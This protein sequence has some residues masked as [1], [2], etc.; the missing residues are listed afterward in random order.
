M[1][2]R[3]SPGA[4]D[5]RDGHRRVRL[6]PA[7]ADLAGTGA[8]GGG[9]VAYP[10]DDA[11]P[12]LLAGLE[13]LVRAI[14]A[15][16]EDAAVAAADRLVDAVRGA[17]DP[18]G[19]AVVLAGIMASEHEEALAAGVDAAL[20][21]DF[22]TLA[23]RIGRA[24]RAPSFAAFLA[25]RAGHPATAAQDRPADARA[26]LELADTGEPEVRLA[27]AVILAALVVADPDATDPELREVG[28]LLDGVDVADA[29]LDLDTAAAVAA[30]RSFAALRLR[31]VRG[32]L[33][34]AREGLDRVDAEGGALGPPL[35]PA[36]AA[37]FVAAVL[38]YP[39]RPPTD[40]EAARNAAVLRRVRTWVPPD[41]ALGFRMG[42]I[43]A[44]G[45]GSTP[46]DP[47]LGATLDELDAVEASL[48]GV[49]RAVVLLVKAQRAL[50]LGDPSEALAC[51]GRLRALVASLPPD[52]PVAAGYRMLVRSLDSVGLDAGA[53]ARSRPSAPTVATA[54]QGTWTRDAVMA[55]LADDRRRALSGVP[56]PHLADELLALASELDPVELADARLS[57]LQL[58]VLTV[59][60]AYGAQA[61]ADP[62]AAFRKALDILDRIDA[63]VA[64][65]RA[66]SPAVVPWL[67]VR[68][69][70]DVTRA[71]TLAAT[72]RSAEARATLEALRVVPE[73]A[74]SPF[75]TAVVA[76]ARLGIAD[77]E[78]NR[79]EVLVA[80]CEVL[81]SVRTVQAS[82]PSARD[83]LRF[84]AVLRQAAATAFDA[85]AHDAS[86]LAEV[87][88]VV[89]AQAMP[90]APA[91]PG[92][93]QTPLAVLM[94][95]LSGPDAFDAPV[96]LGTLGARP[97]P[98]GGDGWYVTQ[99]GPPPQVRMPGGRV[100]LGRYRTVPAD[101]SRTVRL[102]IPR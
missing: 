68:V 53:E 96:P 100:A 17:Q 22:L 43:W 75:F 73:V 92:P 62:A 94:D 5:G 67:T 28:V 59:P 33:G 86:T 8:D 18:A 69:F 83:R 55:R 77:M 89:R 52:D 27:A 30:Y 15:R 64:A 23:C 63:A 7:R 90:T 3:L 58:A 40:A 12:D 11:S 41:Q 84:D 72:R 10:V 14:E 76:Q 46:E 50:Y 49:E 31:D 65:A 21:H 78:D 95:L 45:L 26:A 102:V 99:L 98:D 42:L 74:G 16:D 82:L 56:Q 81:D 70:A 71:A 60:A 1:P 85:A 32:A 57:A 35:G 29:A 20:L 61:P 91:S 88:Q 51:A 38:E 24:L 48:S 87:I 80:L 79:E 39:H 25:V 36:V 97:E 37:A 19:A 13:R 54:H 4:L 101:G 2:A 66:T 6:S 9:A 93:G 44:V 34:A 47:E